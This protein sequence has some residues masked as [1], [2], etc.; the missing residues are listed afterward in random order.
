LV[1][2]RVGSWFFA[3]S[4]VWRTVSVLGD[5]VRLSVAQIGSGFIIAGLVVVALGY[6]AVLALGTACA[7]LAFARR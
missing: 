2:Q 4:V 3:L 6:A 5:A 7:R 1:T